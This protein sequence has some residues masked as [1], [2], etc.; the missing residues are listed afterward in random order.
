M[1][2]VYVCVHF[3]SG[4]CIYVCVQFGLHGR[5]EH[6]DMLWGDVELVNDVAGRQ[7]LEFSE[8]ATK[9][10]QGSSRNS[11]PFPPKMF[12]TGILI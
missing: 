4:G 12:A 11:R 3:V 1:C 8:R 6:T 9:T 7:Y 2:D 10:R 5:Q